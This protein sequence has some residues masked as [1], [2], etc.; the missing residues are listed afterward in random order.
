MSSKF[1]IPQLL[2]LLP[3]LG[4]AI[5]APAQ[6]STAKATPTSA[7]L[8]N[9]LMAS[10]LK[11]TCAPGGN[12]DL[13]KWTLQL[14]IGTTG[15]PESISGSKLAGCNGY[16]Q[17]DYFYTNTDGSVVMKVPGGVSTGCVTTPNS[18]HCRTELREASP[19]SWDPSSSSNKLSAT[20]QVITADDSTHGTVIGQ[21]H[22]DDSV[23]SKPV[24]ELFYNSKGAI[25]IG[26]EQT[27]AGGNE[28]V[29]QVGSV[30]VGSKFSY[31]IA[32]QGGELTVAIN[33]GAAKVL[34]TYQLDS[35]KSYFKAGNY[36]QG[37]SKSEVH[38]FAIDV[39]H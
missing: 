24:C 22:I 29:T 1:T 25:S 11:P 34:D 35:P 37:D 26:V 3:F 20:L 8:S 7:A 9:G 16:T 38:F 28:I 17:K 31:E 4:L 19:S 15:H 27:R 14:P 39:Q 2:V 5:A 18:K 6:K 23:S 21:I 10:N 30:A 13:S 36:N 33:G 12:I 32:Y